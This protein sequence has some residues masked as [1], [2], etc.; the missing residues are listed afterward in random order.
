M[1]CRPGDGRLGAGPPSR[2][3]LEAQAL[4]PT[5]GLKVQTPQIGDTQRRM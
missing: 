2:A 5:F 3:A 1:N 4:Q